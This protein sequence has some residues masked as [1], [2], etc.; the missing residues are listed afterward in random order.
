MIRVSESSR[1]IGTALV[2]QIPARSCSLATRIDKAGIAVPDAPFGAPGAPPTTAPLTKM[3]SACGIAPPSDAESPPPCPDESPGGSPAAGRPANASSAGADQC[4]GLG[5]ALASR[6]V[7]DASVADALGAQP[8][9]LIHS[10]SRF[11]PSRG[12]AGGSTT[13]SGSV[14]GVVATTGSRFSGVVLATGSVPPTGVSTTGFVATGTVSPFGRMVSRPGAPP[15]GGFSRPVVDG[16]CAG[17]CCVSSAGSSFLAENFI[18][19][20]T[21]AP[22]TRIAAATEK[23]RR[24]RP[25]STGTSS[26]SSP[27]SSVSPSSSAAC[28]P[29]RR[30][31][32]ADGSEPDGGTGSSASARE[33]EEVRRFLASAEAA[34]EIGRVVDQP[35]P[36]GGAVAERAGVVRLRHAVPIHLLSIGHRSMSQAPGGGSAPFAR[37]TGAFSPARARVGETSGAY[38]QEAPPE[39]EPALPFVDRRPSE[40]RSREFFSDASAASGPGSR[41]AAA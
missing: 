33:S 9:V 17:A 6:S 21:A 15:V 22:M 24:D 12:G 4:A 39:H 13:G 20:V 16:V 37:R 32:L 14:T 2:F 27:D 26:S 36:G 41:P 7:S 30:S 29:W 5:A 28:S 35:R 25:A 31:Q 1:S 8:C 11:S 23:M 34:R 3:T 18:A 10:A 19:T 38:R 40:V